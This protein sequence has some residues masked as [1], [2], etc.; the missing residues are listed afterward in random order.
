MGYQN[1]NEAFDFDDVSLQNPQAFANG[2][3]RTHSRVS[4]TTTKSAMK[5]DKSGIVCVAILFS[6][7]LL[8]YMDRYTIAGVLGDIQKDFDIG[9]Q[10]AGFLQTV[11]IIFFMVF[12]PLCGFLGDRYNRKILMAVGL[13]IWV[14]AVLASTFVPGH[15]FWLFVVLRGIVGIGEASYSIIA[16]TLIADYFLGKLRSRVLMLF[17]FA[18]PVGR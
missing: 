14:T 2:T 6:V 16:P 5:L 18:I 15:L 1:N 7:N 4:K 8:N 12:A 13:S 17:Y 10:W 9:D 3:Q 11:F